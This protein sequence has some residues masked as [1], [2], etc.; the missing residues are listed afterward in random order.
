MEKLLKVFN[1]TEEEKEKKYDT[2]NV[3]VF[4]DRVDWA[5]SYLKNAGLMEGTKRGFF[6]ILKG[7]KIH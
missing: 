4:Y 7:K 3:T 1:L 5:L 2:K 6:R